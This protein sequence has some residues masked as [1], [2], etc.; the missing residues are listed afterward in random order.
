MSDSIRPD[1]PP[2]G[3]ATTH[4]PDPQVCLIRLAGDLDAAA[5]PQLTD[6]LREYTSTNPAHLV[7]DLAA[8]RFLSSAGISMIL[9]AAANAEGIHGRLHLIGVTDNQ[10][11]THVL[12]LCGLLPR[13][14]IHD[15]LDELL[16]HPDHD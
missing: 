12:E 15:S 2:I 1:G 5:T 8:V 10:F 13:L 4:W 7:L 3:T 11:V 14:D 6:Y 16:Q 9:T